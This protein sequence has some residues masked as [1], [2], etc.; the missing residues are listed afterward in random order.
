MA[1]QRRVNYTVGFKTDKSSLNQIKKSLEEIRNLTQQDVSQSMGVDTSTAQKNLQTARKEAIAVEN[2]IRKAFN[3]KLNTV[4]IDKFNQ[5]LAQS[6]TSL[7][8]VYQNFSNVG[9]TGQN[10]FRNLINQMTNSNFQLKETSSLIKEMGTTLMNT[11]KWNIASS[12]VNSISGSIQQA[13]GYVKNLDSSLNDI[14]IVT[15]KS[16]DEMTKFAEKANDA[17]KALK[18]STTDYTNASLIFYQQGL[19]DQEVEARTEVTLK[20]ANVTQQDTAEV[21]EQL[22]AIWNGYKVSAEEAELYI[23]KVAAVA[24][25]TAADLEELSTGMSK[26]ASAANLMGVDIDQLNAQL[27]TVVSVTRQAPESVGTAFKTIYARMGDI[28]AGLDSE[29]TLGNYTEKMSEMGFNVLDANGKLRDM[30]EVIEEIGGKWTTLSREQQVALSQIMAGTRQYNNLLSLFDNWDMYT[31]ALKTSADAAGTL[32]EQ[33]DIYAESTQAHLQELSTSLEGVFDSMLDAN[34]INTVTDAL[35]PLVNG[36]ERFIDSIGGGI[37]LLNIF[38]PLLMKTLGP[39]ISESIVKVNKNLQAVKDNK[40]SIDN[41]KATVQ[42][43]YDSEEELKKKSSKDQATIK[44]ADGTLDL[45]RS[46]EKRIKS[47]FGD[48]DEDKQKAKEKVNQYKQTINT[49]NEEKKKLEQERDEKKKQTASDDTTA[50]DAIDDEYNAKSQE[51]EENLNKTLSKDFPQLTQGFDESTQSILNANNALSQLAEHLSPEQYKIAEQALNDYTEAVNKN[52]TETENAQ[53]ITDRFNSLLQGIGADIEPLS[54]EQMLNISDEDWDKYKD[55]ITKGMQKSLGEVNKLVTSDN[56]VISDLEGATA[57]QRNINEIEKVISKI[58]SGKITTNEQMESIKNKFK[59]KGNDLKEIKI[60]LQK[61]VDESKEIINKLWMTDETED[62]QGF[63]NQVDKIQEIAKKYGIA[64]GEITNPEQFDQA[65]EKVKEYLSNSEQMLED[66]GDQTEEAA[67][68]VKNSQDDLAESQKNMESVFN[69]QNLGVA[70]DSFNDVASSVMGMVGAVQTFI[71]IGDIWQNQDLSTAEK[72]VQ[73][74]IAIGTASAAAFN[75]FK[76][77]KSGLSGL[78]SVFN[79]NTL[80]TQRN[81]AATVGQTVANTVET[82]SEE[83]NQNAMRESAA[84]ADQLAA[85]EGR[86]AIATGAQTASNVVEGATEQGGKLAAFGN[87]A[88]KVFGGLK[89]AIEGFA[90]ALGISVATL[91]AVVGIAAAA[92]VAIYALIKAYNAD[93]DA[94]KKAAE[95]HKQLKEAYTAEKQALDDLKSDLDAYSEAQNAIDELVKGTEE[96][97]EATEEANAQVL[98]LLSKYPELAQYISD[99]DGRLQISAEGQK[100]LIDAQKEQVKKAQHAEMQSAIQENQANTTNEITQASRKTGINRDTLNKVIADINIKGLSALE[101]SI[102]EQNR[103]SEDQIQAIQQNS[104]DIINLSNK[105]EANTKANEILSDTLLEETLSGQGTFNTETEAIQNIAIDIAEQ[106]IGDLVP[107]GSTAREELKRRGVGG[108]NLTDADIQKKY[109]EMFN[110]V[111]SQNTNEG[112]GIYVKADGT[113]QE[114]SDEAAALAILQ[115][116]KEEELQSDTQYFIDAAKQFTKEAIQMGFDE[117]TIQALVTGQSNTLTPEQIA[118]VASADMGQIYTTYLQ[119][120][121]PDIEYWGESG[122]LSKDE[123]IK[124]LVTSL[125]SNTKSLDDVLTEI[126]SQTNYSI[127]EEQLNSIGQ[128]ILLFQ[129]A[130]QEGQQNANNE[131]IRIRNIQSQS[132]KDTYID[133][134]KNNP[135]LTEEQR[136]ALLE[137]LNE[138]YKTAGQE[139]VDEF[140]KAVEGRPFQAVIEYEVKPEDGSEGLSPDIRKQLEELKIAEKDFERYKKYFYTDENDQQTA[141]DQQIVNAMAAQSNVEKINKDENFF[142]DLNKAFSSGNINT[143]NLTNLG[144]LS[145]TLSQLSGGIEFEDDWITSHFDLIQQF[146]NGSEEARQAIEDEANELARIAIENKKPLNEIDTIFN[147]YSDTIGGN[148]I[149]DKLKQ[150]IDSIATELGW[151]AERLN[152]EYRKHGY[153]LGD[154]GKYYKDAQFVLQTKRAFDDAG[155]SEIVSATYLKK[156]LG[157]VDLNNP[158]ILRQYGLEAVEGGYRQNFTLYTT[159]ENSVEIKDA[160]DGKGNFIKKLGYELE[161]TYGSIEKALANGWYDSGK[162]DEQGH[163]IYKRHIYTTTTITQ[164]ER[165]EKQS[166]YSYEEIGRRFNA[167][168]D[169]FKLALDSM[170]IPYKDDGKGKIK[171][172]LTEEEVVVLQN[173]LEDQRNGIEIPSLPPTDDG[174]KDGEEKETPEVDKFRD[175]NAELEKYN[176]QLE[177]LQKNQ[178]DLTGKD[179]EENLQKQA[180][181]YKKQ[182]DAIERKLKLQQ[183]ELAAKKKELAGFGVS[184]DEEGY[185]TNGVDRLSANINNDEEY[186]KLEKAISEYE[187]A[188]SNT[189]SLQ[190]DFSDSIR[191][192]ANKQYEANL[193]GINGEIDDSA[194]ALEK[195]QKEYEKFSK[196]FEDMTDEEKAASKMSFGDFMISQIEAIDEHLSNLEEKK[197]QIEEEAIKLNVG[198]EFDE[199]GENN[200]D[201]IKSE[202][203]KKL[204][205]VN[206]KLQDQSLDSKTREELIAQSEEYSNIIGQLDTMKDDHKEIQDE[207]EDSTEKAREYAKAMDIS[208]FIKE[209]TDVYYDVNKEMDGLDRQLSHLQKASKGLEGTALIN[210]L[211]QQ[212]KIIDQQIKAQKTKIALAKQELKTQQGLLQTK[213]QNLLADKKITATAVFDEVGMVDNYNDIL[214]AMEKANDLSEEDAKII[215]GLIEGVNNAAKESISLNEELLDLEYSK[216]DIQQQIQDVYSSMAEEGQKAAEDA[217]ESIEDELNKRLEWFNMKVDVELDISEATRRLNDLKKRIQGLEDN[218]ILGNA[219]KNLE[220]LKTY[221]TG[222]INSYF[223]SM[224]SGAISG[225]TSHLNAIMGE[226]GIMQAGGTS[227]LYGTDQSKAFDDLNNYRDQLMDQLESVED[228]KEQIEASYLQMIDKIADKLSD[229]ADDYKQIDSLIQHDMNLIKMIYGEN[230]FDKLALYFDQKVSNDMGALAQARQEQERW[231]ALLDSAEKGSEAWDKYYEN[232]KNATNNLNSLFESSIQDALDR[233]NNLVNQATFDLTKKLSGGYN[234]DYIDADWEHATEMSDKYLDNINKAYEIQSLR[235]KMNTSISDTASLKAQQKI[236][237]VMEEQLKILEEK[238]YVTQYDV[239]RANKIYDITM[240][241]IALEEAQNNKSQMKLRRD[242]QGNYRYEY[243]SDQDDIAQ[244]EQELLE[245]QNNLYNFDKDRY[246]EVLQEAQDAYKEFTSRYIEILTSTAYTEEE[247]AQ[248]I[249]QLK[250]NYYE[251]QLGRMEDLGTVEGNLLASADTMGQQLLGKGIETLE[252]L[253]NEA[254]TAATELVHNTFG[255]DGPIN[256]DIVNTFDNLRTELANLQD[257]IRAMAEQAGVDFE[258]LANGLDPAIEY[259]KQLIEDNKD[260]LASYDEELIAIQNVIAELANLEEAYNKVKEAAIAAIE[261]A[262]KLREQESLDGDSSGDSGTGSG[263]ES[264]GGG[265]N[266]GGNYGG[267]AGNENQKPSGVTIYK[268]I[269]GDYAN[270]MYVKKDSLKN[271]GIT[272]SDISQAAARENYNYSIIDSVTMRGTTPWVKA[273]NNSEVKPEKAVRKDYLRFDTGGYTGDWDS[274]EGKIAMLHEKE[275]VL[276]K[277]DTSNILMAVSIVRTL[278]AKLSDMTNNMMNSINSHNAATAIPTQDQTLE[279]NVKI[280]ASFPNVKNSNDIEQALNNLV[281]T[282]SMYAMR[283][284]R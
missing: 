145:D 274:K 86:E 283:T 253:V 5:S 246:R 152:E 116:L 71:G 282:A 54:M 281:N 184:F 166:S 236:R 151:S 192:S 185:I 138:V 31:E 251:A 68:K 284:K 163:I 188:L 232:Y 276:N 107:K 173:T 33:Q 271:T 172:Y 53:N 58:D 114:L 219:V 208:R 176:T 140:A 131:E 256:T 187:D 240:K 154:D 204:D 221:F 85:A 8:Q 40:Q 228:L 16:A 217:A 77:L 161:A 61:A 64:I 164:D 238:E 126:M 23:D 117:Q 212:S 149:E 3:Q 95:T 277:Q 132:V 41:K 49:Y 109:A 181:L 4:N 150:E 262:L 27:A 254:D 15:G 42:A 157:D 215:L 241:Q 214:K 230:S 47:K 177:R 270:I 65:L 30:G 196:E 250:A 244:K 207:I 81:T 178:E 199:N 104:T 110:Y 148:V 146:L 226:I 231:K 118:Q 158:E 259:T 32:Q 13:Y 211:Q 106:S 56:F 179:L 248:L 133:Y 136:I 203:V 72:F 186:K 130:I 1:E 272:V 234:Q 159:F 268:G 59:I 93:A 193:A 36:I 279:Q 24:A 98:E 50:Q 80:A 202:Y 97:T 235:N 108:F 162:K 200:I 137:K 265:N 84:E 267:N 25:T 39:Q 52:A 62:K 9:A 102:L 245:A 19:G 252:G 233:Y 14:R 103:Y 239:D 160:T 269:A 2:A 22:T 11:V 35:T 121:L 111:S 43:L 210:N 63:K 225:L 260:L 73:T 220:N 55:Q 37:G 60:N 6:K 101:T 170:G 74:M 198:I 218:D 125:S 129:K 82:A 229:I 191:S 206:E 264:S 44:K 75:S 171:Y 258:Q 12:A 69:E 99:V 128:S 105:V 34:M 194:E 48:S 201:D 195:A 124:E 38:G 57:Q 209:N 100:A 89:V 147:D 182:A 280:E 83:A 169:A 167:S 247:K 227:S 17:A 92:G 197:K 115:K 90:G 180:E 139:G 127:S 237:D 190:D 7:A 112:T 155:D 87:G 257:E 88:K 70:I 123:Y 174:K 223:G 26:V 142:K 51:L 143:E 222:N 28:E 29:T 18:K 122:S 263:T 273:I 134:T 96:W 20:A 66:I 183:Q 79:V 153:I 255:E 94:A 189:I 67:D 242:S 21:S 135:A 168:I 275:L 156:Y 224:D 141:S 113:E 78:I 165:F 46:A 261:E 119:D 243:V 249:D 175:I 120:L 205:E 213:L 266:G 216:E 45:S 278:S 91:G 10:A 76:T 144:L